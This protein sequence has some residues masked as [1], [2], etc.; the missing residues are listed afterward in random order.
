MCFPF[1]SNRVETPTGQ[2][3]ETVQTLD[4]GRDSRRPVVTNTLCFHS[5]VDPGVPCKG[6]LSPYSLTVAVERKWSV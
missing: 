3:P 2:C 5:L 6:K 1:R 4:D